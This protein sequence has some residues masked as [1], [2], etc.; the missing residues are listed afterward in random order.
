RWPRAKAAKPA[1]PELKPVTPA[2][3]IQKRGQ[4]VLVEFQATTTMMVQPAGDLA[5]LSTRNLKDPDCLTVVLLKSEL[6]KFPVKD[7]KE[8]RQQYVGN[9]LRV[10]GVVR[11]QPA[12]GGITLSL[13]EIGNPD[14]IKVV[15]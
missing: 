12:T 4:R 8:L 14:H 13:I 7:E 3:A 1:P 5:L 11:S 15:D 2:E 9:K 6:S 10:L